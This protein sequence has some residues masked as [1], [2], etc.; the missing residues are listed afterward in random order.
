MQSIKFKCSEFVIRNPGMTATGI[1]KCLNKNPST[2]SARLYELC[3]EKILI[4]R[5]EISMFNSKGRNNRSWRY[6]YKY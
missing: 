2:V 4:K 6:Y 1:A 5:E 3:Q